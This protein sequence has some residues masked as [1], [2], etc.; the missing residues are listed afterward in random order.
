MARLDIAIDMGTAYTS[1]FVSG[2]G[3][4]LREPT[5]IAYYD[6][7]VVVGGEAYAMIGRD[8]ERAKVVLPISYGKI[9]D[10]GACSAMLKEFLKCILP[11]QYIIKPKIRAV[12]SVPTG[13]DMTGLRTY[14]EVFMNA[15]VDEISMVNSLVLA[16]IGAE[17]P[18]TEA[19]GGLIAS[20]GAGLPQIGVLSLCGIEKGNGTSIACG[21]MIDQALSASIRGRYDLKVGPVEL[22][23]VK[24][25]VL[26][27]VRNDR[28]STTIS[29]INLESKKLTREVIHA[30]D[31][32][33][34][35]YHYYKSIANFF[36]EFINTCQ[37][38]VAAEIQKHGLTLVGG[39]AK[40]QGLAELLSEILGIRVK[41][42]DEPEYS[43][44]F[45]GGKLL[46]DRELLDEVMRHL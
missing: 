40:I 3:V 8:S 9:V 39:G 46:S 20:M 2:Y 35:I 17:L 10:S 16:G 32:Y 43:V 26:S 29:G 28:A 21:N 7:S 13:I 36:A 5:V 31:L 24:E 41:V 1:I 27:L 23:K 18:F 38:T 25:E 12:V 14:E 19:Y 33:N 30:E 15:G 6:K 22:R 37:P 11:E 4:V 45:G 44:V 34:S 42:S